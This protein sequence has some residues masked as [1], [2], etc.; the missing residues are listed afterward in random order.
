MKGSWEAFTK[1]I[2]N[3]RL[4]AD[5][6]AANYAGNFMFMG[7]TFN[8]QGEPFDAFKNISTREYLK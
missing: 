8:F 5:E 1:A 3:G 4:S 6:K 7:P 2:R